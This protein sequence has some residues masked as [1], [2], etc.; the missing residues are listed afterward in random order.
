[1]MEQTEWTEDGAGRMVGRWNRQNGQI[2]EQTEWKEGAEA[3]IS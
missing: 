2:V 3:S 1:M